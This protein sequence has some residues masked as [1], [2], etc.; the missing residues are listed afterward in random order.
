V[1][2]RAREKVSSLTRRSRLGHA[3]RL[4]QIA[5]RALRNPDNQ[6]SEKVYKALTEPRSCHVGFKAGDSPAFSACL[7][8]VSSPCF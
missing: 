6:N 5:R 7:T 3:V 1:N 2:A 4:N 8:F